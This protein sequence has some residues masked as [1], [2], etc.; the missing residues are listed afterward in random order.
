MV[1]A[2]AKL[3]KGRWFDAITGE[4]VC[5]QELR[6][7]QDP[8][9]IISRVEGCTVKGKVKLIFDGLVYALHI[10]NQTLEDAMYLEEGLFTTQKAT[11]HSDDDGVIRCITVDGK[12]YEVTRARLKGDESVLRRKQ[13]H[14]QSSPS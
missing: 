13:S 4:K 6:P 10:R 7:M 5:V 1:T 8:V 14:I 2:S 9:D 3:V 12:D 11:L